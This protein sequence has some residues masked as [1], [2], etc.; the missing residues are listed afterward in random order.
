ML[1]EAAVSNEGWGDFALLALV[2]SQIAAVTLDTTPSDSR[3]VWAILLYRSSG[4]K[5]QSNTLNPANP[6]KA[7]KEAISRDLTGGLMI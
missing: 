1:N 4:R 7:S 6:A 5:T 2:V 3:M